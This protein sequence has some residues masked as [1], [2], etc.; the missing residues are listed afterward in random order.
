MVAER[1]VVVRKDGL[2]LVTGY[3]YEG[4]ESHMASVQHDLA[5]NTEC[6]SST[7]V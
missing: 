2:M 7:N 6:N 5:V 1:K 3:A 4:G